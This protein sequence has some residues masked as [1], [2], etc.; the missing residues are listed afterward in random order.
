MKH[1]SV[2]SQFSNHEVEMTTRK[3]IHFPVLPG[4]LGS[5][6]MFWH[7]KRTVRCS[8]TYSTQ[9]TVQYSTVHSTHSNYRMVT[10]A[11]S[12]TDMSA[13]QECEGRVTPSSWPV[14]SIAVTPG[15]WTLPR[16][17]HQPPPFC[18]PPAIPA[19]SLAGIKSYF[20]QQQKQI[21]QLKPPFCH[22]THSWIPDCI[23]HHL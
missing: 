5:W 8:A 11:Q 14:L 1:F 22:Q 19:P 6:V 4:H 16:H 3:V 20:R 2:V 12:N 18:A 10:M 17:A 9:Y 15:Y 21:T 7:S 13:T 23:K